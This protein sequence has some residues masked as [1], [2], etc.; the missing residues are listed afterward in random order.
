LNL[1]LP[2][3]PPFS[4]ATAVHSHGW[5]QLAPFGEDR[6]AGVLHC[7]IHLD[8]GRVVALEVREGGPGVQVS[9]DTTLTGDEAAEVGRT[10]TWMLG[11]D[12]DFTDFYALAGDEP[13]LAAMEAQAQGRILR[14]PTLFEDT[15]KTILTTNTA[16]SGTIRM[17][18]RL[19]DTYGAPLPTDPDRKAFP[20]PERLAAVDPE[21]LRRAAGLGYRAPY[22]AELAGAVAGGSLDM[23]ALRETDLPT[24]ELRKQ[25]LSIKGVG[26]YAAANLLML[27]GRYDFL[28][29]DS[30]ALRVVSH[31]WHGGEP[32]GRSEVEE[33]FQAWGPWRGLAYWF[34]DWSYNSAS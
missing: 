27:L 9:P 3:R 23:E 21:E 5:V 25:L 18:R 19:V 6:A 4:L 11:L 7:V 30:W 28:P 26:D 8:S 2:A 32:I 10:V 13:K 24:P 15:V 29:V 1:E 20:R 16:W 14:S 33:A 17:V 34:W 12:Q 31:E 22:V